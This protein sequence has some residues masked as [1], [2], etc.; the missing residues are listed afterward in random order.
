MACRTI[1]TSGQKRQHCQG[2]WRSS[3][4]IQALKTIVSFANQTRFGF[5][6]MGVRHGFP[7]MSTV[8]ARVYERLGLPQGAHQEAHVEGTLHQRGVVI[9]ETVCQVYFAWCAC[10]EQFDFA[11]TLAVV[12]GVDQPDQSF[13]SASDKNINTLV[14]FGNGV[15]DVAVIDGID[16]F[17]KMGVGVAIG[18]IDRDAVS[19]NERLV[20]FPVDGFE[21]VGHG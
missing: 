5:Q 7:A 11:I 17:R 1:V 21:V 9:D 6:V 10:V 12:G 19:R 3:G 14:V 13:R 15:I 18:A 8:R 16:D 20:V 2:V 4:L